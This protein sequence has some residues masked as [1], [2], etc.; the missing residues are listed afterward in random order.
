MPGVAFATYRQEPAIADDDQPVA[1]ALRRA[2]V[3]VT[4]AV[5]DNPDQDWSAFDAVVIRS[6][7]DYHLR[8][9][10]FG[11]WV[12]GFRSGGPRL[13][14]PPEAVLWNVHKRYLFDLAAR[15]V[16][17]VPT[18]YLSAG[19]DL[20]A[21]LGRRGW[22]DAV[23][24]PAVAASAHGAWR[25]SSPAPEAAQARLAEQLAAGEVL[26]QPFLP[27]VTSAGE[28]S[29][30]FFGSEY[31]HAVRKR[32]R[33][34]DFRV[35][36]HLGGS[37]GPA[38]PGPGLVRQAR[39]AVAAVGH[40]LLYARVDGVERGGRLLVTELEVTEPSL[41]LAHGRGAAERFAEAIIKHALRP[42]AGNTPQGI[43]FEA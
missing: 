16:N 29:L 36:E 14:N 8:A 28:W 24:K 18:K 43:R 22:G 17:V 40:P 25:V 39:A 21:V 34:G 11:R 33:G 26:V 1:D 3:A 42:G 9:D 30:I 41:Y 23:V 35:Q 12:R 19:A 20:R 2:G 27:E 10:H 37:T 7:W 13:Y 32:P 38:E 5:W 6:T 31:S 15:G 4:A